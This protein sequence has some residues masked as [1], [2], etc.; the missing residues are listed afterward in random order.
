M[1]ALHL[2]AANFASTIS[3]SSKPVLVDFWAP[4][5]GPC[6]ALGPIID[7][8]ATECA[9]T[10]LIAKLDIDDA[11]DIAAEYGVTGIPTIIVFRDGKPAKVLRGLQPKAAIKAALDS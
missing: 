6:K 3:S 2:T 5:C 1:S 11:Q 10:A 8:L 9:D 7:E 4:W